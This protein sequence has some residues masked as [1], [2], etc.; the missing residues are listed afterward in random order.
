MTIVDNEE[1]LRRRIV[2]SV[3]GRAD[4]PPY[5]PLKLAR[6]HDRH[7]STL[8]ITEGRSVAIGCWFSGNGSKKRGTPKLMNRAQSLSP[9]VASM[10][11]RS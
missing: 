6:A 3:Y 7:P 8:A 4:N 1:A 5:I 2:G 9:R 11:S 10:S